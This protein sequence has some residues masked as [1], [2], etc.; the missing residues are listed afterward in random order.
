MPHQAAPFALTRASLCIGL[1]LAALAAQAQ[2]ASVLA[3]VTVTAERRA[4]NAKDVPMSISTLGGEKLDVLN[5]SGEDVRMLSGRVPSLN[6]ESS[7]GRAFPRFYIRGYGNTDF[8]L[9]ASQ[10]VSLIYDDVVQENP[11]L[12]GFPAFD[13]ER[14]EVLAGPQGTLFGRNTPAG[15]VKFES[16]K[17][18]LKKNGGYGSISYGSFGTTNVEGALNVSAS[19]DFAARVSV[20]SQHRDDWVDNNYRPAQTD[21]L[22]GYDDNAVRLQ[23]LYQPDNNFSALGNVHLRDLKGTARLFRA[24]II[25]K[26]SNDLVD[27][28]D[29]KSVTIDGKNE[30]TLS[31]FGTSLRLRWNLGEVALNS[32]S[33][34]EHLYTYS[35][36][37]VDGGFGAP[38]APGGANGPGFIPFSSETSDALNGHRQ[39]SQEFRLESLAG[40]PLKWQGGV[41]L[42]RERYVIDSISYDTIFH[43]PDT[44]VKT[45]QLNN[46]WAV[47]GSANY[48]FT[49]QLN[50]R[51][52]LRYTH[53]EKF[54]STTTADTP[55]NTTA[56]TSA[57]TSDSKV[58]W[59]LSGTYALTPD[60][61]L[62]ARVATGFRASSLQNASAFGPQSK[63]GPETNTS[64]EAGVKA[65]LLNKRARTSF[66]V[67]HYDVKDQ[68]LSAVGGSQNVTT[69]VSAK[70]A[71]GQGV[72]F[73]LDAY[74]TD[75]LLLTMN[76]SYNM[77]KIKDGDLVVAG[78]AQCTVNDP[79][80]A[81]A[82]TY[83][84]DGNPLPQAPKWIGN[85]TLR[86]GLP[87]ASGGEYFVYTD[88]AYRSKINF[89]LYESTE[90]T[91]KSL[92]TG[93]LRL[94]YQ[95]ANGKY[96]AAVFA[97]NITNEIQVVGGIDFNNLT[98]F[99]NEPRT[100]GAQFKATF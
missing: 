83:H 70:K 73:S 88:W 46:A 3:P 4:E 14:I 65:D 58:N 21:K 100:F 20:Q 19:P 9:N 52:G 74:L 85:V 36:G 82:G 5:S 47:F 89:F 79:A 64:Y 38:Y 7:F 48:Q 22:E 81:V 45:S 95:W 99:I 69:L 63:A 72:E 33:G 26:G 92:L 51:G 17:P 37:D 34:F 61:N 43:G 84:I 40:G 29:E 94:G 12:K 87:S 56:G 28:F 80:G 66:S 71:Q 8:H 67:F 1:A 24:N 77:T 10:P 59:D 55:I 41:Y 91:G 50:V 49:P 6:I 96:E 53:D 62:Y 30:Q 76:G 11:I 2:E 86:Y 44:S 93:G 42:F 18:Q 13:L 60:L 97:R 68:Q 16:V 27:G 25:K 23:A 57:D 78:C 31:N 39:Y 15:V 98:G 90:F 35:R 54:L 32:I 75:T